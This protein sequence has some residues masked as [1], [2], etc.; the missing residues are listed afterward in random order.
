MPMRRHR[1][2]ILSRKG[3]SGSPRPRPDAATPS[4]ARSPMHGVSR[5]LRRF[6]NRLGNSW[7]PVDVLRS[8]FQ[9]H[10]NKFKYL[11]QNSFFYH[12]L[13]CGAQ[14]DRVVSGQPDLGATGQIRRPPLD[15]LRDVELILRGYGMK[16]GKVTQRG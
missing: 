10:S 2:S 15:K 1:P 9:N 8:D 5:A 11:G 6:W 7:T 12:K 3:W 16:L 13:S 4:L 14:N